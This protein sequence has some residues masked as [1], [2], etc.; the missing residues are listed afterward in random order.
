MSYPS[1]VHREVRFKGYITDACLLEPKSR[2]YGDEQLYSVNIQPLDPTLFTEI[3]LR[4]ESIK[5]MTEYP[6][7]N[8]D[9]GHNETE[10]QSKIVSGSTIRMESKFPP[11]LYGELQS[12]L[13]DNE[14]IYKHVNAVGNWQLLPD[15]NSFISCHILELV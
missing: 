5:R 13:D 8:P 10:H 7:V 11:R 6:F 1:D 9:A 14:F 2:S 4:E 15:G 12:Y 3:E